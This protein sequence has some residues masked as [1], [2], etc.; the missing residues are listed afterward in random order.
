MGKHPIFNHYQ[1]IRDLRGLKT[2]MLIKTYLNNNKSISRYKNIIKNNKT[3]HK[4]FDH[5]NLITEKEAY[6]AEL[7][8]ILREQGL[9]DIII[10][11]DDKKNV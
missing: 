8:R 3:P 6:Q 5:Q 7:E 2:S 10:T 11:P 4:I 9:E 1:T